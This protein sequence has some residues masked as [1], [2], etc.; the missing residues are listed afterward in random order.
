[1]TVAIGNEP[2]GVPGGHHAAGAHGARKRNRAGNDA[3]CRGRSRGCGAAASAAAS[4]VLRK[5][6]FF[7]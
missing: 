3:W 6:V 7:E 5:P 1:M 4:R 2:N